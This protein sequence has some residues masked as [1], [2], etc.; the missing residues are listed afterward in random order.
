MRPWADRSET[1]KARWSLRRAAQIYVAACLADGEG[2]RPEERGALLEGAALEF[3]QA[4]K[5]DRPKKAP[6]KKARK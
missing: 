1:E 3:A 6:K 5:S 2:P 4:V